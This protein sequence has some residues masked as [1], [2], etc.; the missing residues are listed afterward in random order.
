M[1][2]PELYVWR[3]QHTQDLKPRALE[4]LREKSIPEVSRELGLSRETLRIWRNAAGLRPVPA[5]RKY[6]RLRALLPLLKGG[7]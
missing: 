1:T 6:G 4:M 2:K 5:P 3:R 7:S